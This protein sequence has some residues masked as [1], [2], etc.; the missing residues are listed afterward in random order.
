M[1]K[2]SSDSQAP[3]QLS[4]PNSA[5]KRLEK[6]VGTWELVGRTLDSQEDNISG[7][8]TFEWMAGGFFLKS[9]GEINFKGLII[10]SVEIIAYDAASE[11]F[12]SNV[13]S[14]MS[15][16]VLPYQWNV[17]GN[18][19]THWMES[20]KYSGTLSEDGNTLSGG[21]R[22]VDGKQ[23]SENGAYDAVMTRVK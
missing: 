10:Q 12:P 23:S 15:G 14:N 5:L 3:E 6:L 20:A 13:Y 11:T 18:N 8:A 21:W 9:S 16:T 4:K 2:R 1:T 17:Q 22:P 7:W 19:V